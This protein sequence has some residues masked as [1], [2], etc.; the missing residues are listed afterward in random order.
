MSMGYIPPYWTLWPNGVLSFRPIH[1]VTKC[2]LH[3]RSFMT[4]PLI[5]AQLISV[6]IPHSAGTRLR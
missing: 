2:C 5:S 1:T 3:H 4:S 6:Q